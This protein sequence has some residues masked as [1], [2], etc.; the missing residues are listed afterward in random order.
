M[1]VILSVIFLVLLCAATEIGHYEIVELLE[2]NP[3]I[4]VHIRRMK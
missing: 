3:E 4:E 1:R 2:D